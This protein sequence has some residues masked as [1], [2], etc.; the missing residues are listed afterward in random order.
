MGTPELARVVLVALAEAPWAQLIAVACQPDRPAGRHLHPTPPP[1]KVEALKRNLPVFQPLRAREPE[2]LAQLR[3]LAPDL[4]IVAAYGQ[5][6]PAALLELPRLGCL[7]VHTSLLPRWR[8]AAPIQ[9]AI[10][11]GDPETGVTLMKM[12]AGLDTG[13]TLG[14]I[15]TAIAPEDTSQSL[16][17]RLAQLGGELLLT[18]V[19][20]YA[21][22]RIHPRPQPTEGV[23]LA[24]KITKED[25]RIDWTQPASTLL[26]RHR[27]FTPWPG[28]Y[29]FVPGSAGPQLLKVH[30]MR[31]ETR[32]EDAP[33]G[34]V[35]SRGP[36][37]LVV[38]CGSGAL[39]LLEVQ[40]EGGRRLR[41]AEFLTGHPLSRLE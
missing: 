8:G 36:G 33:P 27:A 9:W 40:L 28:F 3:E 38:A 11:S 24:R 19:P 21:A 41:A 2:F 5:L 18:L 7:N 14:D 26:N 31:V 12:D 4:I 29:G 16:H 15:R 30:A 20:E 23:T 17:D 32:H 22:G 25:G 1:V 10:A 37:K 34:A 13:P 35:L 6:L 39:D